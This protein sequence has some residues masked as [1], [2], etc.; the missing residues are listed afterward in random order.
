MTDVAAAIGLHQLPRL[1]GFVERRAALAAHYDELL[2]GLPVTTPPP[3]DPR[4]GHS[5][6]LYQVLVDPDCGVA[7]DAV[8]DGLLNRRIGTGVH[9]R[10]VHLHPYYRTRY[11]IDP[12]SLPVA[13]DISERTL[14]LPLMPA[15]TDEDQE[16]VAD[17]LAAVLSGARTAVA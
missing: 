9:Y 5:W 14:S 7:R 1:H 8:L 15:M 13:T 17:A 12:A 2:A 11:E 3:A 6:H 16:D 10:G 4:A